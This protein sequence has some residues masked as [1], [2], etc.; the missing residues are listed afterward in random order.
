MS[1][2]PS[3]A[4]PAKLGQPKLLW[5]RQSWAS[6]P[7]VDGYVLTIGYLKTWREY[8][9]HRAFSLVLLD[10]N[11]PS[12]DLLDR[13][14]GLRRAKFAFSRNTLEPVVYTSPSTAGGLAQLC[15]HNN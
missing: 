13:P 15:R 2:V 1:V 11:Y 8:A 9:A 4:N 6:P 3:F 10:T 7:A 14:G 12:G 5:C